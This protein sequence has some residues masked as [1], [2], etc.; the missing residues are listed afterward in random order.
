MLYIKSIL[1][2]SLIYI[3]FLFYLYYLN[4]IYS[5]GTN[6]AN[7]YIKTWPLADLSGY[8]VIGFDSSNIA[9][10]CKYITKGNIRI[11]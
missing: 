5:T 6:G 10:I 11:N 7:S 3:F 8:F 4:F 1:E 2:L 9:K